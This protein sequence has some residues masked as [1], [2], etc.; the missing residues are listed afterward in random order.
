MIGFLVHNEHFLSADH[1]AAACRALR[2][3]CYE[4][5]E[6]ATQLRV[7]F[8]RNDAANNYLIRDD[9]HTICV[10]GTLIF[11]GQHGNKALRDL[12]EALLRGEDLIGLFP[13]FR[14]PYTLVMI[15][16]V[17]DELFI[18][19]SREGLRHCFM[20]KHRELR[21]YSTN[22]LLLAALVDGTACPEAIRQ[23]VHLGA[24]LGENTIFEEVERVPAASLVKC[25]LGKWSST[26]LWRLT[27]RPPDYGIS[28]KRATEA[29]IESL[30]NSLEFAK[31]IPSG[32]VV[33]DLTGGTDS[34][35]VLC[36]L[37]Q[38]HFCPIAATSGRPDSANV[39]IARAVA[40]KLGIE[41]DWYESS[42]A[43]LQHELVPQAVELSDGGR[44][45]IELAKHL[46][47]YLQRADR[48]EFG[49]GGEAGPLFKDHYWLFEFN[50]VGIR[51]E[52]NWARVAQ[53]S[54]VS[55]AIWDDLFRGFK[56]PVLKTV[57]E[58]FLRRSQEVDGSN[59]QK[60]DFVYF[61]LKMPSFAGQIFSLTTQFMDSFH[62]LT[63][64]NNVEYSINLPTNVRIRNI[65]QFS[66]IQALRP[67]IC[68][69][70]TDSGLPSV[71][72]VGLNSWLRLLRAQRYFKTGIRKALQTFVQR[73][74]DDIADV[75]RLRKYG[76]L[77]LL[78]YSSLA[79]SE[80]VSARE[81]SLLKNPYS[82]RPNRHYLTHM[83]S[84]QLFFSRV[85]QIREQAN[86]SLTP[87]L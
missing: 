81:L 26:R 40:K 13:R 61:D 69:I 66:V 79:I 24:V 71:P 2:T 55:H 33:A 32:R 86:M 23:F 59:N 1:V 45:V 5:A 73:S 67:Q 70:L 38:K 17:A 8:F 42:A 53:F 47:Y 78:D 20:T 54:I 34:R 76:Y 41:H 52:P 44:D 15:D 68:W 57:E 27:T 12:R 29:L 77:D 14:G 51:R 4:G 18:L 16:K 39:R 19:N 36:S 37:M 63:D 82:A 31:N 85:K 87:L 30:V 11:D 25:C 3:F 60:L 28:I 43:C 46:P 49:T 80:L 62:P 64:G 7:H 10:A 65:L 22:L 9:R 74:D 75:S 21:A 84:V 83:I 35:M 50:R 48:Y 56:A 58:L 72:P 6:S